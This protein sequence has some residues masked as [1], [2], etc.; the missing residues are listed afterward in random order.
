MKNV[1]VSHLEVEF[2]PTCS[3]RF[4]GLDV[5][6]AC[7]PQYLPDIFLKKGKQPTDIFST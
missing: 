6:V 7:L 1:S 4:S 5:K 2:F 3:V